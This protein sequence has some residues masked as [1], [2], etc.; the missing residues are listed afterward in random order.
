[1]DYVLERR[2]VGGRRLSRMSNQASSGQ[3]ERFRA[4]RD[5]W[6]SVLDPLSTSSS[7]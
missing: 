4:A 5:V 6:A 7:C 1:V 2:P 3:A